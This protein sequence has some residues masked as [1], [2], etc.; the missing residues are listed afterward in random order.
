MNKLKVNMDLVNCVLLIIILVL[1][2][3]CVIKNKDG[4][5][6]TTDRDQ[7]VAE[8]AAQKAINSALAAVEM[9]RK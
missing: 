3:T 4:F 9:M 1:V 5:Q 6:V 8:K 7:Q 2:I